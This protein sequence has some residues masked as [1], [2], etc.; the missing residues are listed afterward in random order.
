MQTRYIKD[1]DAVLDYA[2]DWAEWL[3]ADTI[4]GVTWIVSTGL[5]LTAQCVGSAVTQECPDFHFS[6]ALT[7]SLCLTAKWL[8]GN[9]RVW[10]N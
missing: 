5:T 6:K 3:G 10:A 1:P 9:K 4:Q 2:L 7:S 8:L